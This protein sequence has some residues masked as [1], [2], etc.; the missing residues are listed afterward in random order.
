M[1]SI[2]EKKKKKKCRPYIGMTGIVI[3]ACIIVQLPS[4]CFW[5]IISIKKKKKE[6]KKAPAMYWHGIVSH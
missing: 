2:Q 1:I 3:V 5:N 4:Y 6:K